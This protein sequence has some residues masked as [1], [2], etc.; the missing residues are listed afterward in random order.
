MFRLMEHFKAEDLSELAEFARTGEDRYGYIVVQQVGDAVPY[1]WSGAQFHRFGVATEAES[2]LV[3][4]TLVGAQRC[5]ARLTRRV[6]DSRL[7][8]G[9]DRDG[10]FKVAFWAHPEFHDKPSPKYE[11]LRSKTEWPGSVTQ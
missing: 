11:Q 5:V 2:P 1:Y 10:E 4:K 7:V 8:L 9:A 6:G 3:Y